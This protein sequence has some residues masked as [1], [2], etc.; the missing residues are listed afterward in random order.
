[1]L[2]SQVLWFKD[3]AQLGTTEQHS[4]HSRGNR[5]TLTIRNVT[6]TDFGNYSC[7]ASN[8]HGKARA[9]LTLTG[10]A[11]LAVFESPAIGSEKDSYNITWSVNSHAAVTEYRLFFRQQPKHHRLHH[12]QGS[13]SSAMLPYRN[14]WN[15]VVLPGVGVTNPQIP[16]P[17][18]YPGV[19]RQKMSYVIKG[20]Q[21]GMNY[22]ARVQARNSHGWNKMSP[23]FHFTTRSNGKGF[24]LKFFFSVD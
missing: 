13:N 8:M 18:P 5:Y 9:H 4:A 16:I 1:M 14:D 23:I 20:L 12:T 2:N 6:Q 15:S 7:V 19:T 11:G 22:E 10:T 3:T 21:A 24:N 17:P